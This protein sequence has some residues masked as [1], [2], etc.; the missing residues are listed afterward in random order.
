MQLKSLDHV[1]IRTSNLAGMIAW[2]GDILDMHPGDRPPFDIGG[3]W[4]YV[5]AKPIV[6][7]VEVTRDLAATEPKLEHFAISATGLAGFIDKLQNRGI[8]FT[9]DRVPEFPIVQ[10]NLADCDGNHIHIDF[11]SDEADALD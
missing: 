8:S 6:H 3:A 11:H 10:V 7:L 4:L 1:N 2:Y 9:L 5:A